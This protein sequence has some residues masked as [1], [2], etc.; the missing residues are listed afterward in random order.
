MEWKLYN[1][2]IYPTVDCAIFT[3]NT[4]SMMYV[5]KKTGQT[6]YR[7]VGGFVDPQDESY[8]S[9][10]LREAK[11]ETNLECKIDSFITSCKVDDDRYR[12]K[13]DK[14]ITTLFTMFPV[15]DINAKPMDDIAELQLLKFDSL[16]EDDFVAEHKSL[17]ISLKNWLTKKV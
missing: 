17:F 11:E 3:D 7:F 9:A 13:D 1:P 6:K 14:I 16:C 2:I 4:Y 12:E 5:A 15:N 8:Q 10:A